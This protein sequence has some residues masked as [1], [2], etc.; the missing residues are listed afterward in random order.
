LSDD[1]VDLTL[2]RWMLRMTPAQ[3]LKTLQQ[4]VNAIVRIRNANAGKNGKRRVKQ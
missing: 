4:N 1:G 3:R 2:I